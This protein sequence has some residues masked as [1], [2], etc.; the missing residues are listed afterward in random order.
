MI[1]KWGKN[2]ED[3]D[4]IVYL[5]IALHVNQIHQSCEREMKGEKKSIAEL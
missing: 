2:R 3:S 5:I 4:H 1:S